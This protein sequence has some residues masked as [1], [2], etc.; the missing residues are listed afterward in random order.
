MNKTLYEVVGPTVWELYR[1]KA[2]QQQA[3]RNYDAY[4]KT[5]QWAEK[6]ILGL[7]PEAI[8]SRLDEE[9]IKSGG[10]ETPVTKMLNGAYL[11]GLRAIN[12]EKS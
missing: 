8:K 2:Y 10:R 12:S 4:A 9:L 11:R 6:Q 1:D 5:A 7:N 3:E